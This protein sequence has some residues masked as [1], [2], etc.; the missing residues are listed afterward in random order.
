M[1]ADNFSAIRNWLYLDLAVHGRYNAVVWAFL[2]QRGWLPERFAVTCFEHYGKQVKYWL[3]INEQNMMIL[4][5]EVIGTL[6]EGTEDVQ[7]SL[8]QQNHHM[9]LAQAQ[10]MIA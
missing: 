7:R 10:A 1:A 6:A 4:K 9:M 3:T 5:G 2:Q 8:Y